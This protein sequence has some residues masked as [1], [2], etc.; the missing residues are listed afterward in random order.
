MKVNYNN[1][2]KYFDEK[3]PAPEDVAKALTF[4]SYEVEGVEEKEG[5][6]IFDIDVLPNRA[7]DSF[8]EGGVARELSAVLNIPLGS[9]APKPKKLGNP[10]IKLKLFEINKLLG[11]DMS[12]KEVENIFK[13]LQFRSDLN[14]DLNGE[15]FTVT[16]PAERK[17]IKIKADLIEEVGRIYG[18]ENIEAAFPEKAERAPRVNKKFYYTNKIKNFLAREGFSEVYTYTFRNNGEVEIEKPFASDKN[19][20]RTDLRA[21]LLKSLEQNIKN[22]PLLDADEV[23]IFEIGNVFSKDKEYTTLGIGW[24]GKDENIVNK[25]SEFLGIKID[26]KTKNNI[27]ETNF[28][29]LLDK[30]PEPPNSYEQFEKKKDMA[31]KPISLYPFVLRDIAV[32]VPTDKS[33][34]D[35]LEIIKKE[36]GDLLVNTKLFDEFEKGDRISYAFNLVF[37]SQDKTLSD[38]EVNKIM[39]SVTNSLECNGGWKVR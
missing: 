19:F 2:Q 16:I 10:V 15:D 7:G 21:G 27:F 26:E 6:Y 32:W 22:L 11:S 17:D 9:M 23:K 13:R 35:A 31:F 33:S 8:D 28:D 3:L 34:D 38:E 24:S 36:A 12:T 14:A 29:E 25:L 18:Y 39:D 5:D 4:H 20:L 37:Q 30:L 1:L